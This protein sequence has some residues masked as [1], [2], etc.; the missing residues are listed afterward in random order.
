MIIFIKPYIEACEI[1]KKHYLKTIELHIMR[2]LNSILELQ[3]TS[4]VIKCISLILN[5]LKLFSYNGI[6]INKNSNEIMQ[7]FEQ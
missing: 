6:N 1:I 4:R 3:V 7:E 5:T 2:P